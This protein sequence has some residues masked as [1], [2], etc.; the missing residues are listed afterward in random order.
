MTDTR[1]PITE[2]VPAGGTTGTD[3]EPAAESKPGGVP[4]AGARLAALIGVLALV[5]YLNPWT[6]LVIM[7]LVVMITLH[8]LG[9]FIMAKR[10]GMKATE[11]FLGFGPKIWSTQRG[12]TEYGIK[13]IP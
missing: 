1:P 3:P 12:E 10:A 11:F 8:E 6:L 7:A 4:F 9:H 13:A 5:G 2:A